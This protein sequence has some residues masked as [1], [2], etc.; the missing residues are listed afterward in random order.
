MH[1]T[2]LGP[3][4]L[5]SHFLITTTAYALSFGIDSP[6]YFF[7]YFFIYLS[8]YLSIHLISYEP[9]N[10]ITKGEVKCHIIS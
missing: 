9:F 6:L 4:V 7:I 8:I 1:K 5:P 2:I 10:Y 3:L